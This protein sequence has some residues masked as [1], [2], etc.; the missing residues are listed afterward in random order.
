[1]RAGSIP[2][3][4]EDDTRVLDCPMFCNDKLVEDC[5]KAGV[6]KED[7][8]AREAVENY[9]LH[10][11]DG[12]KSPLVPVGL[13][14]RYKEL[15]SRHWEQRPGLLSRSEVDKYEVSGKKVEAIMPKER[16]M[17]PTNDLA[18]LWLPYRDIG[19]RWDKLGL[20]V[21]AG[22]MRDLNEILGEI[23]KEGVGERRKYLE[24]VKELF[25]PEGLYKYIMHIASATP[26]FAAIVSQDH[27]PIL[28]RERRDVGWNGIGWWRKD[29]WDVPAWE[30]AGMLG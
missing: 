5:G 7:A 28:A 12:T 11:T 8:L 9:K 2:I 29:L 3:V 4:L 21:K 25:E 23:G 15:N 26:G 16:V 22:E 30:M 18:R 20:V 10:V 27:C 14:V 6:D 1:M 13:L 19:L 24:S 17:V